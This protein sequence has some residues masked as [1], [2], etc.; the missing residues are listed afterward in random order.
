MTDLQSKYAEKIA[1][2]LRKAESTTPEE[3]EAL[4]SKA[5]ELM[6]RYAIEAGML[7]SKRDPNKQEK[8]V[9]ERIKYRGI[10]KDA[11]RRIG[12]VISNV[13]G[14]R[15]LYSYQRGDGARGG[16]SA[17]LYVIGF[18][19]D[20]ER[21]IAL[22]ASMQIQAMI[23]MKKWEREEDESLFYLDRGARFR[24]RR[25]FLWGFASG[26]GDRLRLAA[27]VAKKDV[28]EEQ[29]VVLDQDEAEVR[30]S[31]ALIVRTREERIQDW[32]DQ[33]YGDLRPGRSRS[34]ATSGTA[35][36][37]AGRKAGRRADTGSAGALKDR[38]ALS[39]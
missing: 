5:Q 30:E 27:E 6:S 12:G 8:I 29:A 20:V 34:Y 23:A 7:D 16:R 13:N 36:R 19:S 33:T 2:L 21:V 17:V 18:E 24:A 39:R 25:E 37:S 14:C 11:L 15:N 4:T 1:A 22:D 38:K 9:E 10:H 3:A 28:V 26:L 32:V 31:V 35:A